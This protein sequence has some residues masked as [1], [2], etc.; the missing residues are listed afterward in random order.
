MIKVRLEVLPSLA[1]SLG[2][3]A[4]SE[5][6]ITVRESNGGRSVRDLLNQLSTK[7]QHFGHFVFDTSTQKLTGR[8]ILFFNGRSLEPAQGLETKL[9][10]GDTL[11][12]VPFIEGG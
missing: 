4:K 5:E 6:V 3:E 11:A 8:A 12:F 2:M 7:Y 1:E 9:N 10:D